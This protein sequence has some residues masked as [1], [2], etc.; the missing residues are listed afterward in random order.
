MAQQGTESP[1]VPKVLYI[2]IV[3][4]DIVR[5]VLVDAVVAEMHARIPQILAC[6]IIPHCCK[7]YQALFIQVDAKGVIRGDSN[8][9]A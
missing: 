4:L 3:T 5:M 9:E 2:G 6:G 1:L 8:I 7:P